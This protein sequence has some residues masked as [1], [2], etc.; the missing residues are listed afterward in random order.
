MQRSLVILL[1]IYELS[2]E[3]NIQLLLII[4]IMKSQ[5]QLLK[6]LPNNRENRKDKELQQLSNNYNKP[7]QHRYNENNKQHNRSSQKSKQNNSKEHLQ[8]SK[9]ECKHSN[10]E[11]YD[12]ML[13]LYRQKLVDSLEMFEVFHRQYNKQKIKKY[14]GKQHRKR[15]DCSRLKIEKQKRENWHELIL[16]YLFRKLEIK[17]V[18]NQLLRYKLNMTVSTKRIHLFLK[19]KQ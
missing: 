3:L 10:L 1:L 7:K 5:I 13:E 4:S 12:R 6:L 11:E 18:T 19:L 14:K 9:L 2:L 16:N 15:I 8:H 17:V